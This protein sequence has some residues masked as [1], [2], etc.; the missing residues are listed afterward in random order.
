MVVA[1]HGEGSFDRALGL[2]VADCLGAHGI[3]CLGLAVFK[4]HR[5]IGRPVGPPEKI[6]IGALALA[7]FVRG[8]SAEV[9]AGPL[10]VDRLVLRCLEKFRLI[11]EPVDFA[12]AKIPVKGEGQNRRIDQVH[13]FGWRGAGS[14]KQSR[15]KQAGTRGHGLIKEGLAA[16]VKRRRAGGELSCF[17]A[18]VIKMLVLDEEVRAHRVSEVG[19]MT[20]YRRSLEAARAA[21][22]TLVPLEEP[23]VR[24]ADAVIAALVSGRKLMLCGNGGSSSDAA[25]IAAEFVCR[26]VGDRRPYPALALGVD[27]G[28]LTAIGND[29][30]FGDAFSRQVR[31]FGQ[32]G[33][34]LIGISSSGKSRNVLAAIEEARRRGMVSIALLGRD[35]GFTKSAADIELI[36]PGENTARIQEAQKFLLHV[37]CEL[38]EEKLPRE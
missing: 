22:D 17:T 21:F 5:D 38:A 10:E 36:V 11:E 34:V 31:A 26:F 33:D 27:G 9:H 32:S 30:E 2:F 23:L 1:D 6:E 7:A 24:A 15:D 12:E 29:Y 28:L 25:H 14:Q 16:D 20:H 35:G 18:S 3:A 19:V 8:K 4:A 13:G 37:L